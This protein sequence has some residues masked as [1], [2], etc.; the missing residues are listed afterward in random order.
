M[1]L[2]RLSQNLGHWSGEHLKHETADMRR[3]GA[4]RR[5][6]EITPMLVPSKAKLRI[7]QVEK[8]LSMHRQPS[9]P[10]EMMYHHL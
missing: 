3:A 5:E 6:G 2:G 4:E 10:G 9:P 8:G 1:D 7:E